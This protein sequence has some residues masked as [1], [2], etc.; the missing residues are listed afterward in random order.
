[1]VCRPLHVSQSTPSGPGPSMMNGRPSSSRECWTWRW[2]QCRALLPSGTTRR[3]SGSEDAAPCRRVCLLPSPKAFVRLSLS[4]SDRP[5]APT[6][7][8]LVKNASLTN[9]FWC[10]VHLCV[11]FEWP[12][13][14]DEDEFVFCFFLL[15][16]DNLQFIC[17]RPGPDPPKTRSL[18]QDAVNVK[19]KLCWMPFSILPYVFLISMR[20]SDALSQTSLKKKHLY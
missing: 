20:L 16:D 9:L 7:C 19:T 3:A 4:T 1:M 5:V 6:C 14:Y 15:Q 18:I 10:V 17:S 13:H 8:Y 2:T 12:D 11:H